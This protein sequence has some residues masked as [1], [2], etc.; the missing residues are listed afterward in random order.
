[1]ISRSYI[2]ASLFYA[3]HEYLGEDYPAAT[4]GEI[5]EFLHHLYKSGFHASVDAEVDLSFF[6]VQGYTYRINRTHTY[7]DI[8][9]RFMGYL[10][11]E[12]LRVM[13]SPEV[14]LKYIIKSH[15]KDITSKQAELR[16][17][18]ARLQE[19]L[20]QKNEYRGR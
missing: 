5:D 14:L 13:Y 4:K 17:L 18:K 12:C 8:K 6:E 1:M 20:Q 15:K 16:I 11:F 3:K 9:S 7:E 2:I 10:P 19:M